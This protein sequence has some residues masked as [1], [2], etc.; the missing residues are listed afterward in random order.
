MDW[1][2]SPI[3]SRGAGFSVDEI[4]ETIARTVSM[5]YEFLC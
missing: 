5:S 1:S 3:L 2:V 4:A